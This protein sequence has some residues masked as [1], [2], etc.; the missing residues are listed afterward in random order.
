LTGN[1]FFG[2]QDVYQKLRWTLPV[3]INRVMKVPPVLPVV[4]RSTA[5]QRL[6][7]EWQSLDL[8]FPFHFRGNSC[9]IFENSEPATPKYQPQAPNP[10]P[11][12]NLNT[13][14]RIPRNPQPQTQSPRPQASNSKHETRNPKRV[15][16]AGRDGGP[17]DADLP[18]PWL[19][20]PRRPAFHGQGPQP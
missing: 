12:S 15:A 8:K 3:R 20:Q 16:G 19:E 10:R 17:D 5:V 13:N 2:R 1:P 11:I 18:R 9:F 7:A 6:R 4:N 14:P